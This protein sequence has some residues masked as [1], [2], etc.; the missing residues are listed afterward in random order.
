[1]KNVLNRVYGAADL[2]AGPM[3]GNSWWKNNSESP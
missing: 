1:M 2:G 3:G